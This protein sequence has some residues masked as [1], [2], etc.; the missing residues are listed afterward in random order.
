MEINGSY[1]CPYCFQI[2]TILVDFTEGKHQVLIED[3]QVCCRPVQLTIEVD[4]EMEEA[5]VSADIP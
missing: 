1:V 5:T 4:A 3:C 2:N